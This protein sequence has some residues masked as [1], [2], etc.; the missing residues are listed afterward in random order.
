ML[1]FLNSWTS[2]QIKIV[3]LESFGRQTASSYIHQCNWASLSITWS[4]LGIALT[5]GRTAT[6]IWVRPTCK[7]GHGTSRRWGETWSWLVG[8]GLAWSHSRLWGRGHS[9][10]SGLRSLGSV[11]LLRVTARLILL[12]RLSRQLLTRKGRCRCLG[13]WLLAISWE[14][15]RLLGSSL[16]TIAC[17]K[18]KTY[19]S[20]FFFWW[21]FSRE[22]VLL[23][24]TKKIIIN[25]KFNKLNPKY[26]ST[27]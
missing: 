7:R 9:V 14:L 3:V 10:I 21:T 4:R 2:I 17:W 11:S 16:L 1:C 20:Y 27:K 8:P 15:L 24:W 18:G 13:S 12:W 23:L 22:L 25:E 6:C 19:T 26:L 5:K